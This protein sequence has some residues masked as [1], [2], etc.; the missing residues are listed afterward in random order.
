MNVNIQLLDEKIKNSGL[1]IDYICK[2]LGISRQ[3]FMKKRKGV[4][5]FRGSE[6]YVLC[7]MLHIIDTNER[8]KIF[9]E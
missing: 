2:N 9:C 1:K 5:K 7:D 8:D 6:I 4:T 3:A